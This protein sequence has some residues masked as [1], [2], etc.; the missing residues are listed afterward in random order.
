MDHICMVTWGHFTKDGIDLSS[1]PTGKNLSPDSFAPLYPYRGPL[2]TSGIP[3]F[4][5]TAARSQYAAWRIEIGNDGWIW[6]AGAPYSDVSTLVGQGKWGA[7]LKTEVRQRTTSQIRMAFEL[8]SISCNDTANS[9]VTL[10]TEYKDALGIP[11]PNVNFKLSNYTLD[12]YVKA[13]EAAK[14]MFL[15][16]GITWETTIDAGCESQPN[17]GY[18]EYNGEKIQ[19]RGAGHLIGTNRMG[20][21]K[22][23]SVVNADCQSW[24]HSNLYLVGC[25][26]FPTTATANPTLTA[27]ALALKVADKI[28]G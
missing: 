1:D 24:D 14:E 20:S 22:A 8:E 15:K 10:S 11:R 28:S 27:A 4:R 16:A 7:D 17:P 23:D 13:T 5:N 12:G 3:A 19:Y 6:P 18:L 2:S 21:N 25:G 9:R 26:V